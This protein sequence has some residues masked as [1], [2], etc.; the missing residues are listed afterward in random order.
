[1]SVFSDDWR[2][3]LREN[4]KHVVRNN[5][6]VTKPSLLTVMNEVG[7]T[8]DDLRMLEIEATMRAEDMPDDYVPAAVKEIPVADKPF[9]P[10]PLE[11]QCPACMELN[12]IPHDADGQPIQFDPDDPENPDNQIDEQPEDDPDGPQQ[13]TLF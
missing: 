5:D 7:F 8:E 12:R 11:C 6:Q 9:E 1:M 4:Y 2:D 3:C 13:L 10:H